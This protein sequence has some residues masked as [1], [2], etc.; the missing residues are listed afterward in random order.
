VAKIL[1]IDDDPDINQA[2]KLVLE[3]HGHEV[4]SA[5]SRDSGMKA[6][7]DFQPELLVLDVMM[8]Q[9]DDG[10]VMARDLRKEGFTAPILML[11]GIAKITG[12]K[13]D[14]D[15]SLVPVDDFQ[16]KPINPGTLVAKIDEL[17]AKKEG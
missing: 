8:D 13:F 15:D 7:A 14:K 1:I 12:L 3:K 2:C 10:I 6:I 16:E 11:T 5:L 4:E 9:P 17:L